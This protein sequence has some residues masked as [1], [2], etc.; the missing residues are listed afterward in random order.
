MRRSTPR[1]APPESPKIEGSSISDRWDEVEPTPTL[2]WAHPVSEAS[3]RVATTEMFA[4]PEV[5]PPVNSTTGPELTL[6][7]PRPEGETVQA[8]TVP[9]GHC[10]WSHSMCAVT[11]VDPSRG[12]FE[13]EGPTFTA[14]SEFTVGPSSII[15]TGFPSTVVPLRVALRKR[16]AC[17]AVAPASNATEP[18]SPPRSVPRGFVRPQAYVMP[19]GQEAPVQEGVAVKCVS[20]PATD[21]KERGRT[22][23]EVRTAT[24][25]TM[26]MTTGRLETTSPS[27]VAFTSTDSVPDVC[28]AVNELVEVVEGVMDPSPPAAHQAYE[29]PAPQ[30]VPVHEAAAVS[31]TVPP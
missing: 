22:L 31:P 4:S 5:F 2:T 19:E 20:S 13:D 11:T 25:G 1:K 29:T 12:T 18:F 6:R 17:P 15:L 26:V 8:N 23:T 3:A 9:A 24:S 30:G 10:P 7:V 14:T 21:V 28:P 16:V 27:Y